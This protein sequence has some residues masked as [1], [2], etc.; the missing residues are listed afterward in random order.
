MQFERVERPLRQLRKMLKDLPQNPPPEEVHKLRTQARRIEAV[1]S[2][3]ESSAP[4][5]SRQLRKTLK[6]VRKAAGGVRD[7]DVITADLLSLRQTVANKSLDRLADHLSEMR[8]KSADR[9]LETVDQQRKP[10]RRR[11]KKYASAI[12]S[13]VGHKKPVRSEGTD[14][15]AGSSAA[16]AALAAKLIQWPILN[17]SNIH[18][19]RLK[20]KE[21]RY[22]LQADPGS[23]PRLIRS[24]GATKDAIGQWHDWQQLAEIAGQ[25][26]NPDRDRALLAQIE[27]AGKQKLT[28]AFAVSNKLRARFLAAPQR[29][30]RAS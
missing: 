29:P 30:S 24:L 19:F 17:S 1:A 22:V 12:E 13:V 3:L 25:V 27:K 18:D 21:L 5:E 15:Q 26:L 11:L 20:V 6:P 23:D 9:L 28:R 4:K 16:A 7:M 14:S 2:A 8:S 10:A